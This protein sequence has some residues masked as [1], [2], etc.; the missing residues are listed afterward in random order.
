[1]QS[2]SS[3]APVLTNQLDILEDQCKT[4]GCRTIVEGEF[5]H[6]AIREFITKNI[7]SFGIMTNDHRHQVPDDQLRRGKTLFLQEQRISGLLHQ[8]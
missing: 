7:H 5:P 1:M 6:C 4:R 3:R 8:P 2:V